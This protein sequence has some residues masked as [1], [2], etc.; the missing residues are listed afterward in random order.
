M[1][2]IIKDF[3]TY[4]KI[5][6]KKVALKLWSIEYAKGWLSCYLD[7]VLEVSEDNYNEYAKLI[8]ELEE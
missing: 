5:A 8:D 2:N 3:A 4:Y 6:K 1:K 7:M